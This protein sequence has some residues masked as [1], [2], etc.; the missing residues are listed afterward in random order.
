MHLIRLARDYT[1]SKM[2]SNSTLINDKNPLYCLTKSKINDV[3]PLVKHSSR[4]TCGRGKGMEVIY[5]VYRLL[6]FEFLVH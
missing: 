4:L 1:K 3:I 2:G 5:T 6:P